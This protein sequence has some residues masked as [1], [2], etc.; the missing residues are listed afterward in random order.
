VEFARGAT[1]VGFAALSPEQIEG[2]LHHRLGTLKGFDGAGEGSHRTAQVLT[3]FRDVVL[4]TESL[5]YN[6]DTESS[7]KERSKE[8][9]PLSD[10]GREKI[11]VLT[12]D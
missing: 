11:V 4:Q 9:K 6:R 3:Q 7:K 8:R 5:I 10:C 12:Q 1:T 2:A